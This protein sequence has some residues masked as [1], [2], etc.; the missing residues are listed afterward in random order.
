MSKPAHHIL[1]VDDDDVTNFLS[2][3][4]LSIYLPAPK[5]DM[6]LNGQEAID[7][8]RSRADQPEQLPDIILLDINMP[9]MDGWEFL[10]EFEKLKRPAF[11]KIHI[12]MFTSSVY[13]EDIDKAKTY[14]IVK[15]IFSKPLDESKIKT[16]VDS[17]T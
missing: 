8:L 13:Y 17:C 14:A 1:L 6:A 12:I 9:V 2:R 10:A 3:E 11:E 15:D 7:F 4:M 5:I 16:I